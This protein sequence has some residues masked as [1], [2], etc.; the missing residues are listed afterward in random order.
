MSN[1]FSQ[2]HYAVTAKKRYRVNWTPAHTKTSVLSFGG[3][4]RFIFFLLI[5]A[6]LTGCGPS[7]TGPD[8]RHINVQIKWERFDQALFSIDTNHLETALADLQRKYPQFAPLYLEQVLGLGGNDS[9]LRTEGTRL[10][11]RQH[12][13]VYDTVQD[14]FTTTAQ[15]EQQI[16]EGFRYVRQYFP[17]YQVPRTIYAT[18][19]PMDAL[20]ALSTGEPSPVFMGED[21]VAIGLQ[22]YLGR[23]FSVYNDPNFAATLVPQFRSRRFSREYLAADLFRLVVDDLY[24]DSSK[25]LPLVEQ[26]V[27]KG[28]RLHLLQQF[29]PGMHDT[30]LMGY[31]GAQLDWC[32]ANQRSI[33]NFFADQQLLYERDPALIQNF[34]TDGPFTRG[35]PPESPGNI[36]LFVGTEIVRAWV[37]KNKQVTPE[38]MLKTSARS[39]YNGSAYKPR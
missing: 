19:G 16:E 39:I 26:F 6:G 8:L 36:G 5:F 38:A 20:P 1:I 21:F 32:R 30:L 27:E 10:F 11:L 15:Q 12:R 2:H 24:P 4:M 29:L 3:G 23:T 14:V 13:Q 37:K 22:F 28:K 18:V 17:D 31:T 33:Y 25:R 9:T 35:L 7:G 34:L